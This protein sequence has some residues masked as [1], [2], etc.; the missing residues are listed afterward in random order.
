MNL[1]WIRW[2]WKIVGDG[3][4]WSPAELCIIV[5]LFTYIH[6][7]SILHSTIIQ[8]TYYSLQSFTMKTSHGHD[9]MPFLFMV[10]PIWWRW[11]EVSFQHKSLQKKYKHHHQ[12]L[13]CYATFSAALQLQQP[14]HRQVQL[15]YKYCF[16]N[17]LDDKYLLWKMDCFRDGYCPITICTLLSCLNKNQFIKEKISSIRT[18]STMKSA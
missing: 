14:K 3:E 8:P 17:E 15:Y 7:H 1:N 13:L 10:D 18:A 12:S 9:K 11:Y 4:P 6:F 16:A 5:I 2:K